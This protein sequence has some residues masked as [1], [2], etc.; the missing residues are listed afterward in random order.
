MCWCQD[1][2][3]FYS[4]NIKCLNVVSFIVW[5][6]NILKL[7][8]FGNFG[9]KLCTNHCL[10]FSILYECQERKKY[11]YIVPMHTRACSCKLVSSGCSTCS[12]LGQTEAE[13]VLFWNSLMSLDWINMHYLRGLRLRAWSTYMADRCSTTWLWHACMRCSTNYLVYLF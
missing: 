7:R 10:G 9:S 5:F 1:Y 11:M 3:T 4:Y 2:E 13:R 8:M 12:R 6:S